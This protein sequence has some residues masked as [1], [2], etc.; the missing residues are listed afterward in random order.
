VIDEINPEFLCGLEI[1]IPPAKVLNRI[2]E[3]VKAGEEARD[4]AIQGLIAG[5][6]ELENAMRS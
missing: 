5:V 6:E 4:Q 3:H 1:P 2:I